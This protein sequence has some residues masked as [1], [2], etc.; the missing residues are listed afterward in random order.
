MT[1]MP[2]GGRCPGAWK[3]SHRGGS[4]LVIGAIG[5]RVKFVR[6]RCPHQQLQQQHA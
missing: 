3:A 6:R 5:R 1:E 4:V 2:T